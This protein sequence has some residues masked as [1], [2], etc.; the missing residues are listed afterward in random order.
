MTS[1][2][3]AR[4]DPFKGTEA[5]HTGMDLA[6][7]TGTRV[8]AAGAGKVAFAGP[9]SGYGNLVEIDHGDGIV[10]RYGHLSAI[11]VAPGDTVAT[12]DLI[13]KSGST[14]RSTGPHLHFELRRGGTP[15]NPNT[16]LKA[17]RTLQAIL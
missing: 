16:F 9:R 13:G 10:S 4:T 1:P 2:F 11:L 12:G 7:T 8:L 14:G 3:G 15:I 5:Y 17:G 6:A